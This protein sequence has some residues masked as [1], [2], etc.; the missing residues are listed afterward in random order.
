[1]IVGE[2]ECLD[3]SVSVDNPIVV[4]YPVCQIAP[5][6]IS[7]L[8]LAHTQMLNALHYLLHVTVSPLPAFRHP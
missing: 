3:A 1:M 4:M 5:D 2:Y 7:Q 8:A 6:I